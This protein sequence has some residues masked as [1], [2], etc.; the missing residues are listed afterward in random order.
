MNN[1]ELSIIIPSYHTDIDAFLRC[2][3][4]VL[5]QSSD[6]MEII[7][8]DDGNSDTYIN[9][10]YS[11]DVFKSSQIRIIY[12]D[13]KGVSAARN[14][15][16]L[17]AQ[18]DYITF[19]DSDDVVLGDF[20]NKGLS[21][22][23]KENADMVIG[24][25]VHVVG[26]DLCN[27]I[28]R[29]S[30]IIDSDITVFTE[31]KFT[32][33]E[34]LFLGNALKFE[35]KKSYVGKGPVA[36]IVRSSIAKVTQFDCSLS[37]YEDTVWNFDVLRQCK[38]ICLVSSV[39]YGYC[40]TEQSASKGFHKDEIS[41]TTLGLVKLYGRIEGLQSSIISKF[42]EHCIKEYCRVVNVYFLSDRNTDSLHDK[43]KKSKDLLNTHPWLMIK[44]KN[45]VRKLDYKM[46]VKSFLIKNNIWL[47]LKCTKKNILKKR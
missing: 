41:R 15:G 34:S 7:I 3:E 35:D 18:G 17:A 20:F 47:L 40:F 21:I 11:R 36:K 1:I 4:S 8:V 22:V 32:E 24:G 25:I 29:E 30:K 10:V 45:E 9:N 6:K 33:V 27:N 38:K 42:L 26:N 31:E 44:D 23:K 43:L 2:I 37:I 16:L 39:W 14:A 12:Q 5:L 13:N 19:V 46:R 28:C